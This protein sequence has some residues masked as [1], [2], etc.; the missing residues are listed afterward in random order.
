MKLQ[1]IKI[2][3]KNQRSQKGAWKSPYLQSKKDKIDIYF[4]ETVSASKLKY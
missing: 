4:L 3:E 1:K 2:K